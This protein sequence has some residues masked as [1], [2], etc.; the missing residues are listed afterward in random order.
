MEI[1]YS[2]STGLEA[3]LKSVDRPGDYFARGRLFL[4]MPRIVVDGVGVLSFPVPAR[5]DSRADRR[6]GA[7]AVRQGTG[8]AGGHLGPR[9]LA[10]RRGSN[11]G[12]RPRLAGDVRTHTRCGRRGAG[13]P[14]RASRGAPLQAAHLRA[15]GVLRGA[16]RHRE[17]RRHGGDAVAVA[18]GGGRRRRAGRPPR[19]RETV[20]DM[21]AEEPSELAFAAFYADC[22]HE[23]RPVR[24]GHRLSLVFNLCRCGPATRGDRRGRPTTT[25][26]STTSRKVSSSSAPTARATSWCG[27]SNTSTRR[28]A[29][30]STR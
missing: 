23:T 2:P 8:H 6:G 20:I 12:G 11:G 18:A 27:R 28:P 21:H 1:T 24:D 26:G 4:P 16:Q 5:A 14:R 30:P 19:G 7:R 29:C 10:D 25:T 17:G 3:L 13:L 22:E 9:L 15:R